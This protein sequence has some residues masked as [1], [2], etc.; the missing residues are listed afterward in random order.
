MM[1]LTYKINWEALMKDPP[2]LENQLSP[3]H[4]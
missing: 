1:L 3:L 2:S 4:R